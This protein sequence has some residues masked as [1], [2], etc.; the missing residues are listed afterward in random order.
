[1]ANVARF[2][3]SLVEKDNLT[4]LDQFTH[5]A[6]G[7]LWTNLAADVGVTAPNVGDEVGGVVTMATGA[8]DNNEVGFATTNALFQVAVGKPLWCEGLVRFVEANV[9]D[10][11][12]AFGFTD[13]F[14]ANL[15][16]D[17]GGGPK[18]T[19]NHFLLYKVDGGTVWRCQSRNG[20]QVTD[21]ISTA[22]AGGTTYQTLRVEIVELSTTQ[23]D[24][25]YSVDGVRLKDDQGRDIVHRVNIAGS[26]LLDFVPAYIK[27]GG[28]ISET[29]KVNYAAPGQVI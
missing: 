4:F 16:L 18:V 25:T 1:M 20:S 22:T 15:L 21:S 8:T 19:G 5:Y 14:G 24:V 17:N 6:S 27:A 23:V 3:Q 10:A 11:N 26:L 29:L 13:V 12:V 7:D 9:D 2:P 28:A